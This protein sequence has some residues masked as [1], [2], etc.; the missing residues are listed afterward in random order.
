MKRDFERDQQLPD[1]IESLQSKGEYWFLGEDICH[2]LKLSPGALKAALWRLAKK[3]AICR[4]RGDFY[5]IVPPEHRL[6]GCLPAQWFIDPLMKYLGL[7]YYVALLSA[8]SIEGAAHQQIMFLQVMTTKQLREVVAGNQRIHFYY[9]QEID[10]SLFIKRKTPLSYFNLS[11]PELTA[12]DLVRYA[13]SFEQLQQATTVIYEL[14]EKLDAKKLAKLV[15]DQKVNVTAAQRLGYLLEIII[16]A[17]L[18]LAAL[19]LA[20]NT[21]KPRYIALSPGKASENEEKNHRWHIYLNETLE[22]DEL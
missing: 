14:A 13:N 1:Y 2:Q 5:V 8:A 17:D 11:I 20:V 4:I 6:A 22:L 15:V 3:Q 16:A 10:D 7:P 12:F 21:Q 18:D 19:E 9:K